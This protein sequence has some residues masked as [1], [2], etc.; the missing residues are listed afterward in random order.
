MIDQFTGEIKL[1]DFGFAK[2]LSQNRKTGNHDRTFTK[3]G[4]PG[5]TAPE[6]L[7]QEDS[8]AL[9]NI[10]AETNASSSKKPKKTVPSKGR[11]VV[12]FDFAGFGSNKSIKKT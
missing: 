7:L 3:C 4:T 5:F 1:V 12:T 2:D 8:S 6:V 10:R 11:D 9:F